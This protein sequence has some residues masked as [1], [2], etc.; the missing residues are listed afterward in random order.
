VRKRELGQGTDQGVR[1]QFLYRGGGRGRAGGEGVSVAINGAD[2]YIDGER[3]G[4]GE[5]RGRVG[6]QAW[7]EARGRVQLGGSVGVRGQARRRGAGVRM[8]RT[9]ADGL[10]GLGVAGGRRKGPG[11]GPACKREKKGVREVAAGW[12]TL[13]GCFGRLGYPNGP[14]QPA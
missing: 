1:R 3:E 13:M 11:W 6:F 2:F 7:R 9:R 12:A 14:F 4:G 5:G 10:S 8:A